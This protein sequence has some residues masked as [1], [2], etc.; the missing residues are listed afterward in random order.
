MIQLRQNLPSAVRGAPRGGW[1]WFIPESKVLDLQEQ[2][3]P[4]ACQLYFI[5]S[6]PSTFSWEAKVQETGR[7]PSKV[8]GHGWRGQQAGLLVGLFGSSQGSHKPQLQGS[9]SDHG[10]AHSAPS[11]M[12]ATGL[13][14][15]WVQPGAPELSHQAHGMISGKK[16]SKIL[17]SSLPGEHP[18][19][20]LQSIPMKLMGYR[21]RAKPPS[22]DTCP[23]KLTEDSKRNAR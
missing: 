16:K 9:S 2:F 15:S 4:I 7:Y 23:A 11:I 13:S 3:A 5:C 14:L 20:S 8:G 1:R 19:L 22:A 18:T 10:C 21:A 12:R 6:A 17:Q